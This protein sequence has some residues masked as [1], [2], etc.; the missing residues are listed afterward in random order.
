VMA[1]IL[2]FTAEEVWSHIPE[3]ECSSVHMALFPKLG[4]LSEE[5]LSERW[6]A[7]RT[8]RD[9]VNKSLEEARQRG[10]IGKSLEAA[11]TLAPA[12]EALRALCERYRD[13][14]AELFIVSEV[15]LAEPSEARAA[16]TVAPASGE[17]CSRCWTITPAPVPSE[18]GPL[19]GR[20]ARAVKVG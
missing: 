2:P 17:K 15:R 13:S 4:G 1:P 9:Q 6:E 8:L 7:L 19:C 10:E 11:V 3:R 18:G 14:L 16:V 5:G 12:D 20:C